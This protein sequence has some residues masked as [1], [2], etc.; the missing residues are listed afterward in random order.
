MRNW[1]V[2]VGYY[3]VVVDESKGFLLKLQFIFLFILALTLYI[4]S[5][6]V[7]K[8]E[9]NYNVHLFDSALK[10]SLDFYL[11]NIDGTL[12]RNKLSLFRTS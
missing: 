5:F 9:S 3:A 10:L 11:Q 8:A 7:A 12:K 1:C 4:S 2:R 6:C